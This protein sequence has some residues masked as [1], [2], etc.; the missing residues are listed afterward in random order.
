M[1]S[2]QHV[3][4][5]EQ[6]SSLMPTSDVKPVLFCLFLGDLSVFCSET[7]ISEAFQKFGEIAG[8]RIIRN[9]NTKKNLSYGFIEFTNVSAAIQAMNEM[10]GKILCGRSIR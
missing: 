10:N 8:V 5:M 4:N 1:E 7:D 6:S 9:R 3:H 2:Q